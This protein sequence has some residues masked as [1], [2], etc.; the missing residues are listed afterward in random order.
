MLKSSS[1]RVDLIAV[2]D[3][4]DGYQDRRLAMALKLPHRRRPIFCYNSETTFW[5][6]GYKNKRVIHRLELIEVETQD[7]GRV[8]R[9]K[10]FQGACQRLVEQESVGEIGQ[11]A[12]MGHVAYL[13]FGPLLRGE[14]SNV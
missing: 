5:T 10:A 2:M 3:A 4:A 13:G 12:I 14:N 6:E 9:A 1:Q 11:A 8:A 7:R